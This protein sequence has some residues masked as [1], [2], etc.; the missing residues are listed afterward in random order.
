ML[1]PWLRGF[2]CWP[3]RDCRFNWVRCGRDRRGIHQMSDGHDGRIHTVVVAIDWYCQLELI[4]A[5]LDASLRQETT[6]C[7]AFLT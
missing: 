2:A 6:V 3:A 4:C 7:G 1:Q 5:C